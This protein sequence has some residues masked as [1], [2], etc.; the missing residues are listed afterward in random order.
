MKNIFASLILEK[1]PEYINDL[2]EKFKV[3]LPPIFKAYVKTFEF[4]KFNPTPKHTVIHSNEKICYDDFA[5]SLN[6]VIEI[7]LSQDEIYTKPKVLP[8]IGSCYH[9]GIC[10]GIG[11]ENADKIFLYEDPTVEL[12]LISNNILEFIS[13]LK[14]VHWDS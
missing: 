14:E 5:R 8:I 12:K 1:N 9:H 3:K 2:E 7:Y 13:E 10:L 6:R 11:K 4:G